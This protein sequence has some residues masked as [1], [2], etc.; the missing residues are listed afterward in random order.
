MKTIWKD[1]HIFGN[2]SVL[3]K[4]KIKEKKIATYNNNNCILVLFI[5]EKLITP[6]NYPTNKNNNN[7]SKNPFNGKTQIKLKGN[8][9]LELKKISKN[10]RQKSSEKM[11]LNNAERYESIENVTQ[12]DEKLN[13]S[14]KN[15]IL[16]LIDSDKIKKKTN[17]PLKANSNKFNKYYLLH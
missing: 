3:K 7:E 1:F 11:N 17:L 8:Q 12:K 9:N 16:V 10:N 13:N 6:E 2:N 5:N 14:I 15:M 4:E